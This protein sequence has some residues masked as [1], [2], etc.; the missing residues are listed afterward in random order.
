MV[1]KTPMKEQIADV[2]YHCNL[3]PDESDE[4]A[5]EILNLIKTT[6]LS[7]MPLRETLSNNEEWTGA[8]KEREGYAYKK[9]FNQALYEINKILEEELK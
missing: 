9:G 1:N 7:K 5:L 6:L 2:F 3:D 4:K 8:T